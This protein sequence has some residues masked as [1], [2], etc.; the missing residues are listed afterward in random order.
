M[1][2]PDEHDRFIWEGWGQQFEPDTPYV[3][4]LKGGA[5]SGN[6][7]HAGRPGVVGGSGEGGGTEQPSDRDSHGRFGGGGGVAKEVSH[8]VAESPHE[9]YTL[10]HGS[11]EKNVDSIM[12]DGLVTKKNGIETTT[13]KT[14]KV[15]LATDAEY[16][17]MVGSTASIMHDDGKYAVFTVDAEKA[18]LAR[19]P[20]SPE[21][22][23]YISKTS[24]TPDHILGYKTYEIGKDLVQSVKDNSDLSNWRSV[25]D[26]ISML[27][28]GGSDFMHE[29]STHA[30]SKSET[31]LLYGFVIG[32]GVEMLKQFIDESETALKGVSVKSL[33]EKISNRVDELRAL[34]GG[35]GSGRHKENHE[36]VPQMSRG[37]YHKEALTKQQMIDRGADGSLSSAIE[38]RIPLSRIDGL[39]PVPAMEG[40]YKEGTP[41]TQPI[42]VTYDP[43][44]DRYMLSAGNHRVEQARINGEDT[45]PAFVERT[46]FSKPQP[47]TKSSLKGG[48]G[49]GRHPY[50]RHEK[51]RSER[52]KASYVPMTS[53]RR[54]IAAE[55][56]AKV[57]KII[58]G[59]DLRD[60]DPFDVIKG[61]YA[62]EVKTILPGAI[63]PKITMHPESLARKE[64]EAKREGYKTATIVV[65][66]RSQNTIY[67][68]KSSLGSFRLSA[69]E[70]VSK[71]ELKLKFADALKGGPG[72][73]RYPKG[74]GG[75]VT[76]AGGKGWWDWE[77]PSL[78]FTT[79]L[80]TEASLPALNLAPIMNK[81]ASAELLFHDYLGK[82]E[83]STAKDVIDDFEG[84]AIGH[85][86]LGVLDPGP[87]PVGET[88]DGLVESALEIGSHIFHHAHELI[89]HM[90]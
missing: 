44:Q 48:P 37:D 32:D 17:M 66:V 84:R 14:A 41:V 16:A 80:G 4:S 81:V 64:S 30:T 72:S 29:T 2:S 79:P 49:S 67:Y 5:G 10:F 61:N 40:G 19:D 34:K 36:V 70:Q 38:T 23:G 11:P 87:T 88:I 20:K 43:L 45:I 46:D 85:L 62:V 1:S 52:A 65:D 18:N 7:G 63:N 89:S 90:S 60:N 86:S 39:E 25:N 83:E 22:Y 59:D 57:A 13:G 50:G 75:L 15:Y 31:N 26:T 9:H 51:D 42:E 55:S 68:F 27:A 6:F 8:S 78:T 47:S 33:E 28:F 74:S 73:G 76:L 24:I 21:D 3:K 56:E 77:K 58:G 12:K 69:M 71:S 53:E 35:P 82:K 54:A